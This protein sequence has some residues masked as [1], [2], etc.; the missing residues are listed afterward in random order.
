LSTTIKLAG[1]PFVLKWDKGAMYDADEVGVYSGKQGAGLAMAAKYVWAMLPP[2]GRKLYPTPRDVF[3]ALPPLSEVWPVITAALDAGEKDTDL[4]NVFGS[5]SGR[6]R[7][8][9]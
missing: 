1:S 8:S 4:K 6:G 2:A 5:T 3:S 7:A 9:S